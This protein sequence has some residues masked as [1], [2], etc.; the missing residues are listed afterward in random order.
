MEQYEFDYSK[1]DDIKNIL[2]K[3]LKSNFSTEK[4]TAFIKEVCQGYS[5]L[6]YFANKSVAEIKELELVKNALN[7]RYRRYH[8][9][10][11]QLENELNEL[12]KKS[13]NNSDQEN[14]NKNIEETLSEKYFSVLVENNKLREFSESNEKKLQM[15]K[16]KEEETASEYQS[17]K[18]I[19]LKEIRNLKFDLE[20]VV[21]ERDTLKTALIEFK[22]Y[23]YAMTNNK[24][25]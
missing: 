24:S 1:P 15:L 5:E 2:N 22:N 20:T 10:S 6:L 18:I 13:K 19:F 14:N 11:T 23:F 4:L 16:I 8:K 12:N 21:K 17:F 25:F 7:E 9:L 3:F